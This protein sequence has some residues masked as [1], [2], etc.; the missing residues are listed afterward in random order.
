M[1]VFPTLEAELIVFESFTQLEAWG[2]I[3]VVSVMLGRSNLGTYRSLYV[4]K[5]RTT[6]YTVSRKVRNNTS[7]TR[8]EKTQF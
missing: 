3:L 6:R 1:N 7:S 2:P 5:E 4:V 8:Y